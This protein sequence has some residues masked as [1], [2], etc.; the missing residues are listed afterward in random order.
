MIENK[1]EGHSQECEQ[2]GPS[3]SFSTFEISV[4]PS[5]YIEST[6]C[7][8]SWCI[9]SFKRPITFDYALS[10]KLLCLK[11]NQSIGGRKRGNKEK[12]V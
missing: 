9:F 5:V 6:K 3:Q 1:K 12:N 10:N 2:N 7:G 11:I 8:Q 4:C